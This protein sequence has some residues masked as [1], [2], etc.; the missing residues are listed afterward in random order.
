MNTHDSYPRA[1][2]LLGAGSHGKVVLALAQ[3]AGFKIKGVCAPLFTYQ[4]PPLWRGIPVLS[5]T[6]H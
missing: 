4:F 6:T 1:L 2:I 3:A 5:G